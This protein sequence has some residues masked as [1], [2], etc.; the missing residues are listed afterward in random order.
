VPADWQQAG[1]ARRL[2]CIR[3]ATLEALH[4]VFSIKCPLH[5]YIRQKA[6]ICHGHVLAQACAFTA[7]FIARILSMQVAERPAPNKNGTCPQDC[8][9]PFIACPPYDASAAPCNAKGMCY[10]STGVCQCYTGYGGADCSGCAPGYI[11]C[12]QAAADAAAGLCSALYGMAGCH[13]GVQHTQLSA[14]RC[15]HTWHC[16][17]IG[18]IASL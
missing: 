8:P 9:Y 11:R 3:K 16:G 15:Q 13:S 12:A 6:T 7:S 1:V 17:G 2:R 10:T 14:V 18:T 5:R 4:P